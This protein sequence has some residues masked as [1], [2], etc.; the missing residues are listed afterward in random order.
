MGRGA[1]GA[2][3][4]GDGMSPVAPSGMLRRVSADRGSWLVGGG[5]LAVTLVAW[6]GLLAAAA[7]GGSLPG[8]PGLPAFLG[9]WGLMMM[10]MMLPSAAP[11][12][13]L[14]RSAGPGGRAA[15]TVWLVAGYLLTWLAVG[16]PV[17]LAQQ[18]LALAAEASMAVA[19]AVP[20]GVAAVLA[21]AGAYQLTPLKDYCLRQCRSPLDFLVQRWRGGAVGAWR[22]GVEHGLY[23]LG[24]CWGLMA[25]LVAAGAMGLAWVTLIALLVFAEKLL[26]GGRRLAVGTGLA[27]LGLAT[28]VALRPD[29]AGALRGGG[30][31][32]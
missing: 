27:L 24:C 20:Y 17:Y 14:Y 32:M 23:C 2:D 1:G 15:H 3:L 28:L 18:A 4:R 25:V 9:A 10:A 26:P 11:L 21:T 19:D 31:A 16:V 22:L 13:L 12:V 29:I 7:I 30:M 8:L 5:L 6:A